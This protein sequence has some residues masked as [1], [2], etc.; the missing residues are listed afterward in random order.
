MLI[1]DYER[2]LREAGFAAVEIIDTKKDLSVYAQT[3]SSSCCNGS[4]CEASAASD[5]R[6]GI[7]S[8]LSRYDINAF[9]ASVQVYG[10]K[11]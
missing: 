3:G 1:S 5:L 8:L 6:D 9:A 2:M 11:G 4:C 7:V 10:I